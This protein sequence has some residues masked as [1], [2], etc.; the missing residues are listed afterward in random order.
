M[1]TRQ[2]RLTS[3]SFLR[4]RTSVPLNSKDVSGGPF[5]IDPQD[6]LKAPY[7]SQ[8]SCR[9]MHWW[10]RLERPKVDS[11]CEPAVETPGLLTPNKRD[12]P[13][14]AESGTVA[15]NHTRA[16]YGARIA[17]SAIAPFSANFMALH[18]VVPD[19]VPACMVYESRVLAQLDSY[20][21]YYCG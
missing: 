16:V 14:S 10:E 11:S 13:C 3:H 18:G 15:V 17:E 2:R 5:S 12:G 6:R 9:A 7:C 8:S 1:E 21:A 4:D 20:S 19:R